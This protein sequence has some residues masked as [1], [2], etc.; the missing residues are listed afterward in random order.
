M[1]ELNPR[2]YILAGIPV[3]LIVL[4]FA[5]PQISQPMRMSAFKRLGLWWKQRRPL[6]LIYCATLLLIVFGSILHEPNNFDGLSYRIPKVLY[7][8]HQQHWHFIDAPYTPINHTLPNYE[9]LTIPFFLLTGGFHSTVVINWVAFLFIPSLFFSLL[10]AFGTSNRFAYDWMWI[11][12]SGYIIAMQA[13]GIGNDLLGLT[14]ILAALHCARRFVAT[15][16]NSF[17]FDALLAAGFC[18]GIK[19]S[20]LPLAA[21]VLILLLKN[22]KR[23]RSHAG[24]LCVA[25][26]L[27]ALVSA[28]IPLILNFLNSGSILG[29][30]S[31]EDQ[32]SNP[33]A[34]ILANGLIMLVAA[35]SPPL[36]PG[37]NKITAL[38]EHQLPAGLLSWLH[39]YYVKFSLR[40]NELPQ[41]ENGALGL[42]IT[43][44][45]ILCLTLRKGRNCPPA[46]SNGEFLHWQRRAWWGFLVFSLL[47][48]FAKLGTGPAFPRN[49]LPWFPLLLAPVL[50]V[51]GYEQICRSRLWRLG[52]AVICMSVLPGLLLTPS[53]PLIPPKILYRAGEI[54]RVSPA[55]LERLVIAYEVYEE[56]SDPFTEIKNAL[57]PGVKEIGLISDGSEPT[58]AWWKPYGSRRCVYLLSEQKISD[59]RESG[60]QYVVLEEAACQKYFDMDISRWL[61]T[62]HASVIT[63]TEVRISAAERP[64]AYTLA[65]LNPLVNNYAP[66]PP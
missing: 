31:G 7:W 21:F 30:T 57:P 59:A 16:R 36:F 38:L 10:R 34:G 9:W 28:L 40:I 51:I 6:P 56:R 18:T 37:A 43:L 22:A 26:P 27:A 24:I 42:G 53:R 5:R 13:G 61:E 20:N 8:L 44:A 45:I 66:N 3:V 63:T 65:K 32:T 50:S 49:M 2:G 33:I 60:L 1:G 35:M 41:E 14:T 19:L 62:Q 64:R 39:E 25:I 55:S 4:Y 46:F 29:T 48:L 52:A 11:L 23:P 17:L 12:P 58:A 54:A 47:V 15:G